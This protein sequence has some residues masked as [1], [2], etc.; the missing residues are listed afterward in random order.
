MNYLGQTVRTER[1]RYTLWPDGSAELYD[2][3]N[4]PREY[5]N[6]ADKPQAAAAREELARILR[7]GWRGI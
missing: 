3:D 5:D 6:L 2:H 7:A 1:W 4:D